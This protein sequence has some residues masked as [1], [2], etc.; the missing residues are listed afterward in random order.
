MQTWKRCAFF[1]AGTAFLALVGTVSNHQAGALRAADGGPTVTIGGP[2]PLPTTAAQNGVWNVGITGTPKVTVGNTVT[3]RNI[4][5]KGR[6]PYQQ[7]GARPCN[8][9]GLCDLFFPAVPSGKRLVIENV[10]ANIDAGIGAGAGINGTFLAGGPGF[11]AWTLPG[12]S[13]AEPELVAV[14]ERVLAFYESGETPMYRVAYHALANN[15]SLQ[16]VLSGYL[17]DLTQ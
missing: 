1:A 7:S 10:S 16:V 14:N 5:E 2:L 6:T 9:M 15:G 13:M 17:V 3:V 8:G 4:D 11:N 12:R